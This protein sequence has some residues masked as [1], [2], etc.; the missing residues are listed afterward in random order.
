MRRRFSFILVLFVLA[1][2]VAACGGSDTVALDPVAEAAAKTQAEGSL[3]VAAT[4]SMKATGPKPFTVDGEGSGVFNNDNGSG[5]M[6]FTMRGDGVEAEFDFVYVMPVMYMRSP[7]F[8]SELPDGKSWVKIN[9]VEAGKALGFD[10]ETLL[11]YRPTD[12]LAS[13]EA[14]A[15]DVE[16]VGTDTV[17][18]IKTTQYRA[19]IDFEKAAKEGPEELREAMSRVAE[20][21]G[22]STVP[23]RVWIDEEGLVRR[24]SQTLYQKLP[25]G[26][27][28]VQMDMTMDLYDFGPRIQVDVPSPDE[29][30]DATALVGPIGQGG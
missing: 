26:A 6:T 9:L 24:F 19:T 14:T 25:N 3:K 12:Q 13:L 15:E 20:L 29:V 1:A 11:N 28:R 8:E 23:V 17:R 7:L 18:G 5:R 4:M 2:S 16:E 22:T 21:T 10:F 27:G 30:F